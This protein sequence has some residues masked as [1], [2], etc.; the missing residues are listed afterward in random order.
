MTT[1][2]PFDNLSLALNETSS[3]LTDLD[4]AAGVGI[5]F[6]K[7]N[8]VGEIIDL[9]LTEDVPRPPPIDFTVK[10]GYNIVKDPVDAPLLYELYGVDISNK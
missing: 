10:D 3:M 6:G 5:V 4:T 1:P 7:P 2:N 8:K 9:P